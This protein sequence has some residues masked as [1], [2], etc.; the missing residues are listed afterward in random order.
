MKTTLLNKF[1]I[2]LAL[3]LGA[4]GY[5]HAIPGDD[6]V[7]PGVT[8]QSV[9]TQISENSLS[10]DLDGSLTGIP[11]TQP[12]SAPACAHCEGN[13]PF[14]GDG[15]NIHSCPSTACSVLGLGYRS[16]RQ[17]TICDS[18]HYIRGSFGH[19]QNRNTGVRGWSDLRYVTAVCD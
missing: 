15:V 7:L 18:P 9:Q 19:I 6:L 17:A 1:V 5:E 13:Y 10:Q 4:C 14:K 3:G 2:T 12:T 16:Q 8:P 11:V